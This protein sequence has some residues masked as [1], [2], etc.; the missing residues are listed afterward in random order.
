VAEASGYT[1]TAAWLE[2]KNRQL[3]QKHSFDAMVAAC[4]TCGRTLKKKYGDAG[5]KILDISELLV[6]TVDWSVMEPAPH[7]KDAVLTYHDPCHLRKGQGIVLQPRKI[8][9]S[10]FGQRFVE[11]EEPGRC[12]G[13]GG[14]FGVTHY[15]LSLK[16]L[17]HKIDD[18][19]RTGAQIVVT[20]CP[21]CLIQL[22]DGLYQAGIKVEARH[23]LE[24]LAETTPK[25]K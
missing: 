10:L 6:E 14:S 3:I 1:E 22:R 2:E 21:G 24:I 15:D 11:M 8:L 20:E 12:C 5:I 16:I 17:Q 9:K 23:L 25:E 4:A 19:A 18:I 7:L 13:S